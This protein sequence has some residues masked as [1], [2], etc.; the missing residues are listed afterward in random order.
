MRRSWSREEL[1][2][3]ARLGKHS[4]RSTMV[5]KNWACSRNLTEARVATAEER[6]GEGQEMSWKRKAKEK[7]CGFHPK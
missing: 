3:S 7:K 4:R 6:R 2:Q 1:V 5:E